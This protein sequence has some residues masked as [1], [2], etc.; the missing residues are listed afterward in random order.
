MR[1]SPTIAAAALDLPE[2]GRYA[3]VIT[4]LPGRH[5]HQDDAVRP[6][7]L[8]AM[9]LL[10]RMRPDYEV[11]VALLREAGVEDLA[12]ELRPTSPAAPGSARWSRG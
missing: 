1:A 7:A 5:D 4:R 6:A 2:L 9:R 8:G 3:V 12:R 11:A 10:W